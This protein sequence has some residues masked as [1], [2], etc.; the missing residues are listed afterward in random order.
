MPASQFEFEIYRIN[1]V[2]DKQRKLFG[3]RTDK[4]IST[5]SDII[6]ILKNSVNPKF[7]V[8]DKGI[9]HKSSWTLRK[10]I[11]FLPQQIDEQGLIVLLLG[12][13][14]I[15]SVGLRFTDTDIEAAVSESQPPLTDITKLFFYM[16]RHILAIERNSKVT[17]FSWKKHLTNLLLNSAL[18]LGFTSRLE[19]EPIPRHEEIMEAFRSFDRLTRLRLTLRLP[20]PEL[21]RYSQELYNEMKDGGIAEYLQDMQNSKGLKQEE[22]KLPHASAEIASAGY[23]KGEVI[24]EGLKNK[25]KRKIRTGKDAARGSIPVKAEFVRNMLTQPEISSE[26]DTVAAI[27]EEINRIAP[28]PQAMHNE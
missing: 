23:K 12:K 5:D 10:Y 17:N 3:N 22:G 14:V 15:E 21:S 13:S 28:P 20:N 11:N 6:N 19:F 2:A 24:L 9:K 18:D 25:K 16:P 8:I 26:E 1:I 7:K 4:Y 27:L